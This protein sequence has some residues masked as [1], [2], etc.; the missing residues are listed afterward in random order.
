MDYL[1]DGKGSSINV[2]HCSTG[3]D[4]LDPNC[5]KMRAGK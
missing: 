5:T 1:V 3:H 4:L 2:A